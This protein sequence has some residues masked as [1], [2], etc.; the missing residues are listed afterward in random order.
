MSEPE[1]WGHVPHL[2]VLLDNLMLLVLLHGSCLM[3]APKG[4]ASVLAPLLIAVA[5]AQAKCR[6]ESDSQL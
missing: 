5:N 6:L 3:V 4:A 2:L 1:T